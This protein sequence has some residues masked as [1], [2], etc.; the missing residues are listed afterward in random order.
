[1]ENTFQTSL[2]LNPRFLLYF[3]K[4]L[5]HKIIF[6]WPFFL[7]NLQLSIPS[8]ANFSCFPSKSLRK[9][10]PIATIFTKLNQKIVLIFC[11]LF[12]V[13]RAISLFYLFFKKFH[14]FGF[15]CCFLNFLAFLKLGNILKL[16][17]RQD[18][19]VKWR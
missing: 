10:F 2:N 4:L 3:S 18:E 19:I 7:F 16:G 17:W 12:Y 8:M 9:L 11:P 14:K 13:R 6:F 15:F 5:D 1:M